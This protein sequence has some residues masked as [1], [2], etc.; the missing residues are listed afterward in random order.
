MINRS[1]RTFS[2]E[3]IVRYRQSWRTRLVLI[4][5]AFT[6]FLLN[7]VPIVTI[8]DDDARSIKAIE[9]VK[10]VADQHGIKITFA[11]IAAKLERNQDMVDLLHQYVEE[12][13]EIASHSLTHSPD[14]WKTGA[15]T[16]VLAIEHE[17]IEADKIFKSLGLQPK[18]FVYPY[19]NFS[20]NV[21][22]DIFE[23]V[24]RYYPLA[25]NARGDINLPG[26]M[27][28]LYISRHPL[29]KHNSLFMMKRLIDEATTA[30]KSWVV[31]LTHSANP[32]FSAE[33]L[34]NIICYA[35]QSGADFLPASAAWQK[36]N[37]WPMM[38]EDQIPDYNRLGDYA[39][40][41]YFHLPLLL[42]IGIIFIIFCG[43]MIY[44]LIRYRKNK[45]LLKPKPITKK[46]NTSCCFL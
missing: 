10:N 17:V 43:G 28:P 21:R 39:N 20:K 40:A 35:Q 33:M 46:E 11:A 18:S 31:I 29:R 45:M 2:F 25:F 24:G 5:L 15:K 13:H 19:G 42:A 30:D 7:A 6:P 27:Y 16:D 14:I 9:T 38:D 22:K 23:V 36:I 8:I 37:T 44:F 3:W 12:G 1:Y 4:F 32:D 26:K 34:E 41:A